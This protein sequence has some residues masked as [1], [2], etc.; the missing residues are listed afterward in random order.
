MFIEKISR[1]ECVWIFNK[2]YYFD[3]LEKIYFFVVKSK[4]FVKKGDF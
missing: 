4:N 1:N 3:E 2:N